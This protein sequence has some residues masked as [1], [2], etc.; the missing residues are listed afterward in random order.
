MITLDSSA[1]ASYL[2]EDG[3]PVVMLNLLRFK[4]GGGRETYL[5]YIAQFES[6]GVQARYAVE[7]LYAG[8]GGVALAAE[9]GQDWDMIL[10]VR[11]PSRQHFTDMIND[12]DYQ[13]FEHLREDALVEAVLQATTPVA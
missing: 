2:E 5:E 10:L 9:P 7:V 11:Y 6:T 4:P 13:R 1:L 3:G 12:P 8:A